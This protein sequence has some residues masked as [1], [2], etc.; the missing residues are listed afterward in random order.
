MDQVRSI[1]PSLI[2]DKPHPLPTN[3]PSPGNTPSSGVHNRLRH[4]STILWSVPLPARQIVLSPAGLLHLRMRMRNEGV[5]GKY[6]KIRGTEMSLFISKIDKSLP[7]TLT[8]SFL[9]V[10]VH[11]S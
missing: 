3:P 5:L 10:V 8:Q 9:A 6:V 2:S 11:D 1:P 7:C 4:D